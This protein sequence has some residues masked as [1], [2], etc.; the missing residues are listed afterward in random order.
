MTGS[1]T[2]PKA[3]STG[4]PV[5]PRTAPKLTPIMS[6][7]GSGKAAMARFGSGLPLPSG[8]DGASSG[9]VAGFGSGHPFSLTYC[10]VIG[11]AA[12][13]RLARSCANSLDGRDGPTEKS[14]ELI[15][16]LIAKTVCECADEHG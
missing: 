6:I 3:C 16:S 10:A 9:I 8:E 2:T 13:S 4:H 15:Y 12:K 1:L 5:R 7:S 14:P 11:R